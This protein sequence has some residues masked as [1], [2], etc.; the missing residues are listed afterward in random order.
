MTINWENVT[1]DWK[2]QYTING[3]EA[4]SHRPYNYDSI[5]HYGGAAGE[6][7]APGGI[8][9][10]R[11]TGSFDGND[12][13]QLRE[14]YSCS[15][16][17]SGHAVGNEIARGHACQEGATFPGDD[18]DA[19]AQ[20]MRLAGSSCA[21]LQFTAAADGAAA[22]C[23]CCDRPVSAVAQP[24]THLYQV[25]LSL[26]P[27]PPPAPPAPPP[28]PSPPP[29]PPPS[30]PAPP[31]PFRTAVDSINFDFS[32][33]FCPPATAAC[34]PSIGWRNGDYNIT[35]S[36]DLVYHINHPEI[37]NLER[38]PTGAPSHLEVA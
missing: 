27:A 9:I 19:C 21:V 2:A 18:P 17:L 7:T 29:M 36:P 32:S 11:R 3:H 6:I 31:P 34:A 15:P 38:Q 5:M 10:G 37:D 20:Q 25:A 13:S 23:R 12:V 35:M 24:G 33:E 30:P 28:P 16:A 4:D 8:R 26:S 14:I 1:E 22:V